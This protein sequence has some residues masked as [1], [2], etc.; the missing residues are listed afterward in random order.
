MKSSHSVWANYQEWNEVIDLHGPFKDYWSSTSHE[1]TVMSQSS[2]PIGP[3]VVSDR[4]TE[5]IVIGKHSSSLEVRFSSNDT[6]RAF[7]LHTPAS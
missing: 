2:S 5:D 4:R 1:F 3:R 6:V 7:Q